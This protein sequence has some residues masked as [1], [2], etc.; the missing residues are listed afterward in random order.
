[1]PVG[2]HNFLEPAAQG[3]PIV[4]GPHLFNAVEIAEK[5]IE[6][7]ACRVVPD[8]DALALA[9]QELI[10]NPA[11]ARTMGDNG[12]AVLEQNRGSLERLLVLVEPLLEAEVVKPR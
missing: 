7:G 9:V 5:F 12:K 8:S 6:L 2:G 11:T 10:E 1:M 4:T 3:V